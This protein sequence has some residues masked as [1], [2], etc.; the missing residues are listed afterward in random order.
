[1]PNPS[2]RPPAPK[3]NATLWIVLCS[4][5]A[6]ALVATASVGAYFLLRGKMASV[7]LSGLATLEPNDVESTRAWAKDAMKRLKDTDGK[8][9][10]RV[11]KKLKAALLGKQVRWSFPV[12]AV[13]EGEVKLDSFFGTKAGAFRSD[14]LKLNGKPTRRLYL[15]VF[16]EAEKDAVK[17]GDE[18]AQEEAGR[19]RKGD[20]VTI[21]R[22]VSEVTL[23]RRD[24]KWV[25]TSAYSDVIDVLEPYCVTVVVVR[26]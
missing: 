22:T 25:S 10:E 2:R 16:F 23:T 9:A 6:L 7:G 19:L 26:K 14:D 18:V 11:E 1:M 3:S 12:V 13:D 24:D 5:A 15:R 21:V 4:L 8:D 17:V 20:K